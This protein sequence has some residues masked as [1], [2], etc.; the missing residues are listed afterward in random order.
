MRRRYNR[1]R[2]VSREQYRLDQRNGS[3]VQLHQRGMR[4][5]QCQRDV[6]MLEW[7]DQRRQRYSVRRMRFR[8]LLLIL[9]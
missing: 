8:L 2:Q 4:V 6:R 1:D 7:L 3:R 5:R 9:R